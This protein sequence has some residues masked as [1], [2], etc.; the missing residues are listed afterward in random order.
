MYW[1]LRGDNPIVQAT[2][3]TLSSIIASSLTI[4]RM[5]TRRNKDE[6]KLHQSLPLC[7]AAAAKVL[8]AALFIVWIRSPIRAS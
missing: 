7:S 1:P 3:V 6:H 4:L 5:V 8:C 2:C